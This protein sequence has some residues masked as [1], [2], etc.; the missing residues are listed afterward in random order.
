MASLRVWSNSGPLIHLAKIENLWLLKEL[1]SKIFIVEAVKEEVV[2]R[3]KAQG[4]A[5]ALLIESAL[6]EGWIKLEKSVPPVGELKRF[7]LHRG[8]AQTISAALEGKGTV[9]LDD[10]A[11]REVA[12]HLGL[13]VRGSLGVLVLAARDGILGKKEALKALDRLAD[14]MYVNVEVYR[15]TKEAIERL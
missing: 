11:A 6:K 3:G 7:G 15:L 10:D 14:L 9:L 12:S 4:H 13:P 5:D 1:Y 8:E 2:D